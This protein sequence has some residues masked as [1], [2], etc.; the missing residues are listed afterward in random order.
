MN[1]ADLETKNA[2]ELV[3]IIRGMNGDNGENPESM[4]R[5]ELLHKVLQ[6]YGEQQGFLLAS[7]ILDIMSDGYGFLRSNGRR[8][9]QG[10]VYVSQ[11]QVRRFGLRTGD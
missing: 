10:D 11:S 3:D 5:D 4:Y 9:R 7:G 8:P 1:I 6:C 2:A